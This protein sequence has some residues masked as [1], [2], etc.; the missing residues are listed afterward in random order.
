MSLSRVLIMAGGTGGHIYPALAVARLLRSEGIE[1]QWLGAQG[2]L[3]KTLLQDA[4]FP[5]HLLPV[6]GVRGRGVLGKLVAV[7]DFLRAIV[8]AWVVLR[9]FKPNLVLGFGGYAS[10]PGGVAAWLM[11][12]PLVI[13]EQNARPGLTNRLLSRFATSILEGFPGAFSHTP[14]AR[15]R[16]VGN[17][18]RADI[19]ALPAP[20]QRYQREGALNILVTGGSQGAMA[21]NTH[22]PE[23]LAATF[24]GQAVEVRHQAGRGKVAQTEAAYR[25]L[26]LAVTVS[27]YI[28]DMAEALAWADLVICRAGA[29][30]VAEVA[31]AGVAA[32][33]IP[34]PS[35]VD[36]HQT[37]NARWLSDQQAAWLMPQA[38]LSA[39]ALRELLAEANTREQWSVLAERARAQAITDS[40]ARVLTIL[41][42]VSNAR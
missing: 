12:T 37:F 15:V 9:R 42:E 10:A 19:L 27:E 36:D 33:F 7:L 25:N 26:D 31:A 1:V 14:A 6:R 4:G 39:Q 29:S 41:R 30:T 28:D 2:G 17:P 32:V 24:S 8:G 40:S 13:H 38:E 11:R 22:L 21:L 16:Y 18:V 3:E 23:V 34:L 5:L 20:A 35:A